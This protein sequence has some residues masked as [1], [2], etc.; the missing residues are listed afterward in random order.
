VHFVSVD[1]DVHEKVMNEHSVVALPTFLAF[2][3]GKEHSRMSGADENKLKEFIKEA[4]N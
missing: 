2:R 3:G 4:F 1:V